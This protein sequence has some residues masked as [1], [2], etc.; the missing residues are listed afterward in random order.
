VGLVG[1]PG[2][3][4]ERGVSAMSAGTSAFV[5]VGLETLLMGSRQR[6]SVLRR[7]AECAQGRAHGEVVDTARSRS[8]WRVW[9][10]SCGV[11]ERIWKGDL[12]GVV[13]RIT[14]SATGG[15]GCAWCR[16]SWKPQWGVET[17]DVPRWAGV[18]VGMWSRDAT[19]VAEPRQV[20][21]WL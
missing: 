17:V 16:S 8:C 11:Q 2:R 12:S 15:Q 9:S 1:Q 7:K 20:V 4:L 18:V 5:V 19:R 3:I 21:G 10:R 14:Q 13:L 6:G